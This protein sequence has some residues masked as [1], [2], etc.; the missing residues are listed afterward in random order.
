[1]REGGREMRRRAGEK[2]MTEEGR[3]VRKEEG[4]TWENKGKRREERKR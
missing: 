2:D 3:E 1:M 4:K